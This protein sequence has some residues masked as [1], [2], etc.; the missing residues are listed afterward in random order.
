MHIKQLEIQ[1]K[2]LHQ[3]RI[4][5]F[6]FCLF[7]CVACNS[8]IPEEY[9]IE[10][11]QNTLSNLNQIMYSTTASTNSLKA[12][13][14][15]ERF[16]IVHISD[17]HLPRTS[18]QEDNICLR[19]LREAIQFANL[20]DSKI[21]AIVATGDYISN[22]EKTNRQTTMENLNLF[23]SIF[24]DSS[25]TI[26][27]FLCTGNHDTNMLTLDSTFYLSKE[28]IHQCLF[29]SP[30]Y[31]YEQTGVEN[32]YYADVK[33]P[34]GNIIRF[35]VLDNTDQEGFLYNTQQISCI[36][37]KQVDWL[38]RTALRKDMTE[39]HSIIILTHHPLQ[40]YSK[41]QETYMCGGTHLYKASL[42]PSIIDAFQQRKSI[43]QTYKSTIYPTSTIQINGD[44]TQAKGEFICYLGGHAHTYGNFNVGLEGGFKQ[45]MLLANTLS[46]SSQN[47]N[48]GYIDRDVDRNKYNSFSIYSIDTKEKKI[49]ITY[50][51]ATKTDAENI[52]SI[53]YR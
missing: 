5:S 33:E 34:N 47:N 51:G 8:E 1:M 20:N 37:Q 52:S 43:S 14:A 16:K 21:N 30:N 25:N 50:F 39:K 44:F 12:G 4:I 35:I 7:Y 2:I 38:I 3:H 26:P 53:S 27:G 9:F 49:Y 32:Y 15:N 36:T 17:I 13:K 31:S 18:T 23:K 29:S 6:L 28:D 46:P 24:F 48:Y 11:I 41:N 19:N 42:I 22:N 40:E 45:M 10:N